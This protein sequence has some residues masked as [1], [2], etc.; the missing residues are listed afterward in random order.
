MKGGRDTVDSGGSSVV[1]SCQWRC[2]RGSWENEHGGW[3]VG[4]YVSKWESLSVKGNVSVGE[5]WASFITFSWSKY[6]F[7][8]LWYLPTK[9]WRSI[10]QKISHSV[11]NEHFAL[12]FPKVASFGRCHTKHVMLV[13]HESRLPYFFSPHTAAVSP[14][15]VEKLKLSLSDDL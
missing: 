10:S 11:P 8:C 4:I 15:A 14:T 2:W 13:D 7:T 5:G 3:T 9:C 1:M 6:R 12:N